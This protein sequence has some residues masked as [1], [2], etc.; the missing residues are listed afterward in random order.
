MLKKKRDLR[1][2]KKE[3]I[4]VKHRSPTHAISL[5]LE[6]KKENKAVKHATSAV[7]EF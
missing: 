7:E 5:L 1:K 4:P 6:K 3:K 2:K